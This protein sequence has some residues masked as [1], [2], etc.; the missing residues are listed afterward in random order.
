MVVEPLTPR[1]ALTV[2]PE[3]SAA[4]NR[5]TP[6]EQSASSDPPGYAPPLPPITSLSIK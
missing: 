6:I 1:D 4:K 2:N 3:D 5:L